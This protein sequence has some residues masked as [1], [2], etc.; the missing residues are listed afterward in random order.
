[1]FIETHGIILRSVKYSEADLMLTIITP[2]KG[3]ISAIAK[4]AKSNKSKYRQS[5]EMLCHSQFTISDTK[6]RHSIRKASVINSFFDLRRDIKQLAIACYFAE[7][8]SYISDN[9]NEYNLY[10]HLLRSLHI[11]NSN[12]LS[13]IQI[14][15]V[16][17]LGTIRITGHAPNLTPCNC[18]GLYKYLSINQGKLLIY[19]R[20][21][22]L[23]ISIETY[24]FEIY[25]SSK[26]L[27]TFLID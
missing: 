21:G 20:K 22:L 14:K 6:G 8:V 24:L 10:V 13:L 2:D 27:S 18:N 3:K 26:Y 5:C 23:S 11:L 19:I 9:Q 1:M 25:I 4:G 12:K 15:S 7:V 16:F 17:E